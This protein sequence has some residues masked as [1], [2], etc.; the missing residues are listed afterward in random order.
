VGFSLRYY[1]SE[2]KAAVYGAWETY[3]STAVI[4]AT[5]TGK[6]ELYLSIAVELR[7]RVL[8]IAHRDY[9]LTQPIAR[10]AAVGFEDV[11]VE[12]ADQ[13]SEVGYAR[14]K[15]VFASVQSLSRAE[16]LARFRPDDFAAV[17]VD[18]GHRAVA[19]Q[20]RR[21]LDHFRQNKRLKVLVLTA[22]PNRKDGVALRNVCESVAYE[23]GP[24]RASDE[25]WIVPLRFFRREVPDLDFSGIDLKGGDLD[26]EQVE[27]AL[28]EEKPLHHICASL[29]DDRG[30]TIVFCPRVGVAQAFDALMNRRYRRNRSAVLWQDSTDEDRERAGKGLADGSLD[31]L[32]NVDIATE[33]YD[34]P[35]LVRVVW[36][37]ATASLVRFTQ[38]TGRVFRPAGAVKPQLVGD[39]TD[40]P[41]R[42]AAI[43]AS[44]KPYGQVVTFYPQNC[45]HQLC[46]P[47]DILGGADL[48]PDV[49][50][51]AKGAQ[52]RMAGGA[53]GADPDAAVEVGETSVEF[54]KLLDQRRKSLKA[55]AQTV[56]REYDGFGGSAQRAAAGAG[57]KVPPAAGGTWPAGDAMTEKQAGW[58]RWKRIAVPEG[59]TK[60]RASVVR[61]LIDA[62]VKPDTAWGYG[63]RQARAVLESVRSATGAA[64]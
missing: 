20:Y 48:P 40:A 24:K 2:A 9:L 21:V 49:K 3:Q 50:A 1:Q 58:F 16:R 6:T 4:S 54:W 29:A 36:A 44:S 62:G 51:A 11:A 59:V 18:E 56:D 61:D 39:L 31:Y 14:A 57:P 10:L 38:G 34:V 41:A 60:L 35:E 37:S 33:G 19:P 47:V 28:M 23:Y 46:D 27:R 5:G 17:I 22:T 63:M 45:R 26:P 7:G 64:G 15:V 25:G 43:A 53:D 32:F 13:R 30:P 42:R 8:V 52:E 12:K 55:K